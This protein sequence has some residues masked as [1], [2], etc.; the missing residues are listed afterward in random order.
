MDE[1]KRFELLAGCVQLDVS[2]R[3]REDAIRKACG[4]L[5][6]GGF[7]QEGY[8]EDVIAREKLW[9][10][11]L[12][13]MPVGVAIPHALEPKNVVEAQIAACRLT[14]A[15]KFAQSGGTEQDEEIDVR[16]VFVLA[17]K[18]PKAQL[19]LLQK[20]MVAISDEE[21]LAALLD[22]KTPS[23]FSNIFN[24]GTSAG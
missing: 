17:L 20:L 14:E 1:E 4:P 12:P 23:D 10:T 7:V 18:D 15:V 6:S 13:T 5:I 8:P 16:L 21:M 3:D 19:H 22:A 9:A 2:A 11:G 24:G